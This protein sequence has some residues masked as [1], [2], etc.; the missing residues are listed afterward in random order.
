MNED[1]A[2][3]L[4]FDIEEKLQKRVAIPV[5][6]D[7]QHG[8]ATV[9][10]AALIRILKLTSRKKTQLRIVINGAGAAGLATT[11]LLLEYGFKKIILCDRA[12]AIYRHRK[13]R[14]NKY[15]QQVAQV[16][17]QTQ[18]KGTLAEVLVG[19]DV[20]IGV[21]S[22][23]IVTEEMVKSMAKRPIVL[24]LANPVPEI[25]PQLALQAGAVIALDGRT[26]NNALAFPGIMRGTLN[27]RTPR[28]NSRMKFA[29][30]EMIASLAK[31]QNIVPDFMDSAVHHKVAQAVEQA[32]R[33]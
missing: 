18:E 20:F 21:S 5:F 8:T 28:I 22:P 6:H 3:P 16:T 13:E 26:I 7:D 27:A 9:I 29:A 10:L 4:C 14:M 32:A 17:N 23:G 1:V 24:A 33:G 30:A 19:K 31:G 2:A 25:W 11:K 15:K 12:G